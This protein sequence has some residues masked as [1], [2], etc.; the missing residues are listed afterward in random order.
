MNRFPAKSVLIL[1]AFGNALAC[2][3][4][5]R[6]KSYFWLVISRAVLGAFQAFYF[7]YAPVW[8]NHFAPR[9]SASTWLSLQQIFSCIGITLGYVVGSF[10]TDYEGTWVEQYFDWRSAFAAQGYALVVIGLL[11]C[12]FDNR[13]IDILRTETEYG[14]SEIQPGSL[15]SPRRTQEE[16]NKE[17]S[18]LDQVPVCNE[19]CALFT[20]A[21]YVLITL[22]I[23]V[24]FFS[25]TGL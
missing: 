16:L 14:D 19:I 22:T 13:D 17:W 12:F 1:A 18:W 4:F 3:V 8:I 2:F 10:A 20:N 6:Q 25:A 9:S 11:F 5:A 24:F 23:T 21:M 7:C 15:A